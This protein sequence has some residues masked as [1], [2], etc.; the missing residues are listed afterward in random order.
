[1]GKVIGLQIKKVSHLK[2]GKS[3]NKKDCK[4]PKEEKSEDK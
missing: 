2:E 3:D 1:M 4:T